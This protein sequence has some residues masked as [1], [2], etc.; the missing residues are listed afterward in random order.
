MLL[1]TRNSA[2]ASAGTSYHYHDIVVIFGLGLIGHAILKELLSSGFG[3]TGDKIDFAWGDES[4][5][6]RQLKDLTKRIAKLK[7]IQPTNRIH[8]VWSAGKAGFGGTREDFEPEMVAFQAILQMSRKLSESTRDPVSFHLLSSA[9]G[10]FEGQRC[11]NNDTQVK[12]LRVYGEIKLEQ[13]A[14]VKAEAPKITGLIYRPSSVYG[15]Q[16]LGGRQGL[17]VTMLKYGL[18]GRVIDIF[19]RAD[20]LRDFILV[21]DIG[22]FISN[23]ITMK[24][25]VP[26]TF[27]L[28]S[29]KPTSMFEMI[30]LMQ[31]M[32]KRTIYLHYT[33][34]S[35]NTRHISFSPRLLHQDWQ[36]TIL[37]VGLQKTLVKIHKEFSRAAI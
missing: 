4:L 13:E 36:P 16:G 28:A 11:V 19:G 34:E 1:L 14:L 30:T 27:F 7:T 5:Q 25:I 35:D 3:A 21:D 26:D 12:P 2:S 31:R 22:V 18:S 6:K 15:Y 20:T 9:G 32:M 10:L 24:T 23:R 29:G 17:V 33:G 37:Q 8:I